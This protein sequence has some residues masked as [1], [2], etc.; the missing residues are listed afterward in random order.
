[1]QTLEKFKKGTVVNKA[2]E[3]STEKPLFLYGI[4]EDTTPSGKVKRSRRTVFAGVVTNNSIRL[5]KAV[6]SSKDLFVKAKG[7][8]IA[9]GRAISSTKLEDVIYLQNNETPVECFIKNV[10]KRMILKNKK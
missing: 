2:A 5:G 9:L 10:S 6:C 1:M 4:I 3:I 8:T 7:R